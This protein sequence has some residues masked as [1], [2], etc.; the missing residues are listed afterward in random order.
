MRVIMM[1]ED[2]RFNDYA[3]LDTIKEARDAIKAHGIK[4]ARI[5]SLTEY[6]TVD[7]CYPREIW[8][9]GVRTA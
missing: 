2:A 6:E 4:E 7:D 5:Y 3:I 1:I 8:E 9:N